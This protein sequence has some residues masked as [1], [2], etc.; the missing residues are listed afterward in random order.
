MVFFLGGGRGGGRE[1]VLHA[2]RELAAVDCVWYYY[3]DVYLAFNFFSFFFKI[4]GGCTPF[5]FDASDFG[6]NVVRAHGVRGRSGH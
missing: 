1:L 6:A 4:G 2:G 5:P 3:F